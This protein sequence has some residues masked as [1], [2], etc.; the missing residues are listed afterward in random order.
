MTTTKMSCA[1]T[2]RLQNDASTPVLQCSL[3][4]R[5]ELTLSQDM[6]LMGVPVRHN[7]LRICTSMS[8][9]GA[10][11]CWTLQYSGVGKY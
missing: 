5:R 7:G 6:A 2:F 1:S 9:D 4:Y 10:A 3:V 11:D 8:P